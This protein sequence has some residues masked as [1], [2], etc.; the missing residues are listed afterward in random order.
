MYNRG[1]NR[2]FYQSNTSSE[3]KV[4]AEVIKPDL[5]MVGPFEMMFVEDGLYYLDIFFT[6][7]GSH[8]FYV[9]E[10]GVKKFR[11][12]LRVNNGQFVIYPKGNIV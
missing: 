1:N 5:T 11:D 8:V 3:Q 4:T 7:F 10:E 2:L 6:D 12:I 9:Y